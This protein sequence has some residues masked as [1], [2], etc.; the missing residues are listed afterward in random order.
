M[1]SITRTQFVEM[2]L[3]A[4]G[5]TFSGLTYHCDE[6]KSRTKG[7]KKMLQKIVDTTATLNSVYKAKIDRILAKNG[8]EVDWTPNEIKGRQPIEGANRCIIE[9]VK[10]GEVQLAFVQEK[11][12]KTKSQLLLN[13]QPVERA[14]VWNETY[15]QPARLVSSDKDVVKNSMFNHFIK[16]SQKAEAE[17][18]EAQAQ[19]LREQ[20]NE[21]ANCE[22]F[23]GLEFY[24]RTLGIDNI[25]TARF[26]GEE[27]LLTGKAPSASEVKAMV[28]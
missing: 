12:T 2:M 25:L 22:D 6:S 17:G 3:S 26:G 4:K 1:K 27:L 19:K 9:S 21:V 8:I 10:T 5:A 13:G 15:I 20:A 7:G 28:A 24:Y 16:A 14:D 23:K 18:N 11:H